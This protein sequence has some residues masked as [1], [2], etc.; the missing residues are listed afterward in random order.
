MDRILTLEQ[1]AAEGDASRRRTAAVLV[2][3]IV[4]GALI[5]GAF[6]WMTGPGLAP[7]A[8]QN[9]TT[10]VI[11]GFAFSPAVLT[12]PVGTTVTW[13]NEDNVYHTVTSDVPGGALQ[14]PNIQQGERWTFMFMEDGTYEYHCIPHP[15]MTAKVVVGTGQGGGGGGPLSLPHTRYDPST[16]PVA[17]GWH[18]WNFTLRAKELN[19]AVAPGV[20]YAAWT[21]D[22]TVP[23]PVFRVRQ[24]DRVTIRLINEGTMNHSID[25]HSARINWATAYVDV[26]PGGEHD[27]TFTADYPGVFMY[28]CGSSPVLAHVANGMYGVMIVEPQSDPRPAPDREYV[29]VLSEFYAS[30]KINADRVYFGDIDKMLAATPTQVV[31]NGYAFQY[32]PGLGGQPLTAGAGQRV[33]LYVLNAG[34]S[35]VESF[36]VIGGIFDRVWIENNPNN[37]LEGIQTWTLPSSGGA[38]F[39]IVFPD[40]GL[41]PFVTHSFAYTGLGA[42]GVIQV[43]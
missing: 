12:V 15:F 38:A 18:W 19:L 31:F 36:H 6:V 10:V 25:F 16:Q 32:H 33:R 28:H 23:G 27:Y 14:S 30:D 4:I 39:D 22:G 8:P 5:L 9:S 40:A 7:N 3:G 37:G 2:A 35:I 29:L 26:P 41:Y 42:V 17:P 34:P 24:G 13:V 43:A 11:K 21:F 1:V 20:P